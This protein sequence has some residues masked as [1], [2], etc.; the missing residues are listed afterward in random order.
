[1]QALPGDVVLSVLIGLVGAVVGGVFA[2]AMPG[3]TKGW[4]LTVALGI[5]LIVGMVALAAFGYEN[6]GAP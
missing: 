4:V 6:T 2:L 5:G 1:M 3:R